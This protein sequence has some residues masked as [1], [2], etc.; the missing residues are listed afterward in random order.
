MM[1]L[2]HSIGFLLGFGGAVVS[3]LLMLGL[4]DT[5]KR[6]RRAKIARRIAPI[7]WIGLLML[8][9]SGIGLMYGSKAMM[10]SVIGHYPIWLVVKHVFVLIILVD[11]LVIHFYFFPRYFRLLGSHMWGQNYRNMRH[12]ATLS[13]FS[14]SVVLFLSFHFSH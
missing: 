9:T 5:E 12:V 10:N 1:N 11:A 13:V 8:I 14:W 2:F 4:D 3:A 7:T 6:L